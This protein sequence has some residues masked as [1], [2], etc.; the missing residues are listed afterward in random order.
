MNKRGFIARD[1]VVAAIMFSG[2]LSL[3]VLSVAAFANDYDNAAIVDPAF[4]EKFDRFDN[5]TK[6]VKEMFE[7]ARTGEGITFAGSFDVLF[8]STF[9]V[10][11]LVFTAVFATGEQLFGFIEFFNIPDDVG[12]VFFVILLSV[13][14]ALMVFIIASAVSRR[15]L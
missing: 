4:S 14:S 3:I 8:T 7:A 9:T 6:R 12:G 11:Q 15:D 2:I 1:F 13:L 10:I 5:N